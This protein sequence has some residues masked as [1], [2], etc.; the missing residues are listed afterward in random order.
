MIHTTRALHQYHVNTRWKSG[1]TRSGQAKASCQRQTRLA[2]TQT[3]L[4]LGGERLI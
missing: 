2:L 4:L 1:S 3:V